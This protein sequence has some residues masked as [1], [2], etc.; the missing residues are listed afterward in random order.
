MIMAAW[1][2]GLAL[3][4]ALADDTYTNEE[5]VYFANEAGRPA[6]PWLGL[7]VRDADGRLVVEPVDRFGAA[8]AHVPGLTVTRTAPDRLTARFADGR[9]SELRRARGFTCWMAI[10]KDGAPAN[11]TGDAAWEFRRG[12]RLH[13]QGG[14]AR[15]GGGTSGAPEVILRMRNVVW[16]AGNSNRP[17][18]VLY[19]H[20][21][22]DPD[23]AVSYSW[24]DP[25]A[26]L[27][28]I[29]LRWMQGSCTLDEETGR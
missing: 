6:P 23:R 22:D 29:N 4:P 14:R 2:G 13:D 11:A 26:R 8:A 10:R 18:L 25:A 20:R 28:G 27:V 9:T 5:E 15:A 24:A 3:Q 17:S 12:L 16:P 19:V 7:R 21:P 1:A